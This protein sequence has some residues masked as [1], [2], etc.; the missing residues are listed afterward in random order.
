[1]PL[2]RPQKRLKGAPQG[3]CCM[4]LRGPAAAG[5]PQHLGGPPRAP[6]FLAFLLAAAACCCLWA[7][8][9]EAAVLQVS[10]SH[11][12]PLPLLQK[13]QQ[14]QQLQLQQQ[15]QPHSLTTLAIPI[16]RRGPL[17]LRVGRVDAVAAKRRPG[18]PHGAPRRAPL[19]A[20]SRGPPSGAFIVSLW[21]PRG[22]SRVFAA[23]AAGPQGAQ[24]GPSLKTEGLPFAASARAAAAGAE[25]PAAAVSEGEAEAAAAAAAAAAAN[26]E[27]EAAISI[28]R[29]AAASAKADALA[30][31]R[32][33]AAAA[34]AEAAAA[35]AAA[36]GTRAYHFFEA[37]LPGDS[38]LKRP[39][40]SLED[41]PSNL[42]PRGLGHLP[43]EAPGGTPGGPPTPKGS[44][45]GPSGGPPVTLG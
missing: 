17:P 6:A 35:A 32:S 1:M 14:Q 27:E 24:W 11:R 10:S 7:L 12:G 2:E 28:A 26:E 3:P 13:Q 8:A 31:E 44:P 38:L 43:T 30:A 23:A 21:G 45:G 16:T 22:P 36:H 42:P 18:G 5:G 33:A 25:R 29:A 39:Y 34:A 9:A 37:D 40:P 19:T 15:Q 4:Q 41:P 20:C